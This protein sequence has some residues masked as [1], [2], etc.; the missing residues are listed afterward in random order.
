MRCM[1]ALAAIAFAGPAR[2]IEIDGQET[3]WR[4]EYF[5]DSDDVHVYSGIAE[6]EMSLSGESR[7]F[8]GFHREKVVVPAI[9][10]A[11]GSDEAVD[12]ISGA[13]R[14]IASTANAYSDFE[15]TRNQLDTQLAWR[16]LGAGYYLSRETDYVAQKVSGSAERTFL[17]DHLTLSLGASWGWDDIQPAA[18]EDTD[19]L[20]DRRRTAHANAVLTQVIGPKTVAQFGV[21][22]ND[23]RGLQHNPYRTVYV[24][25]AYHPETHPDARLRQDAFLKLNQ[26]LTSR[27]SLKLGYGFYR[28]DWGV[29]SHTVQ[30]KLHQYV[31]D[32]VVVGYRWRWYSQ[33]A[34]DFWR[35]E[36]VDAG[37]VDG[38][39]TGDYRLSPF[40]AHLFGSRISWDLG[41]GLLAIRGLEGVQW[42]LEYERYFNT[43]NFSAN[44]FQSGVALAF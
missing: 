11:P 26:W 2:S 34:A 30:A 19:A 22:I 6:Y 27:A 42:N 28:D 14:P 33:S 31:G 17:D 40:D 8:F 4:F 18:D 38:Y 15:K 7:V 23:V 25:G 21:E 13:S 39:Q 5:S 20:A 3:N 41:R 37:G 44:I 32:S 12:A 29:D 35:S 16:G 43:N 1:A 36:Y 9:S 24:A 10:A